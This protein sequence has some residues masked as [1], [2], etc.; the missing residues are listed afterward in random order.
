MN[1]FFSYIATCHQCESA[2][3]H[4][5]DQFFR[6]NASPAPGLNQMKGNRWV[7]V[8]DSVNDFRAGETIRS[9]KIEEKII[10]FALMREGPCQRVGHLLCREGRTEYQT[11][12]QVQRFGCGTQSHT[13]F[14][15]LEKVDVVLVSCA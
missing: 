4:L 1:D 9:P 6:R 7:A 8:I 13:V 2:R 5:I 15:R 10:K 14:F 12:V 3:K 11:G